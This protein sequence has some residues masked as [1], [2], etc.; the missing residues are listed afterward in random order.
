MIN[1]L[2]YTGFTNVKCFKTFLGEEK[3]H[4]QQ[5]RK[6]YLFHIIIILIGVYGSYGFMGGF[7][8]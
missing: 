4:M 8:C 6:A 5:L 2:V 1:R 3:K 7:Y